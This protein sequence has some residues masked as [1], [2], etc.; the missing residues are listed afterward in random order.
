M[1]SHVE[2]RE[3]GE[4]GILKSVTSREREGKKKYA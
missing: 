1:L 3:R 2:E 4:I